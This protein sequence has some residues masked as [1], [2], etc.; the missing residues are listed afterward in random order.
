LPTQPARSTARLAPRTVNL[1]RRGQLLDSPRVRFRL[2][3]VVLV[4]VVLVEVVLV[5]VVLVD[6][7]L[8]D[9]RLV[10]GRPLEVRLVGVTVSPG[11]QP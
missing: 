2:V 5:D 3:E 1:R 6:V 11:R 4:D 8:V 10:E 9:V 7:V